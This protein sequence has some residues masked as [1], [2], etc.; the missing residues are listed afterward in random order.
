MTKKAT[1]TTATKTTATKTTATTTATTTR[2]QRIAALAATPVARTN[3]SNSQWL[4]TDK[5]IEQGSSVGGQAG[6]ILRALASLGGTGTSSQI[7]EKIDQMRS[8]DT[9]VESIM[10]G[11]ADQGTQAI[12]SHYMGKQT[13]LI[14]K[15]LVRVG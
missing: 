7:T 2:E 9:A 3:S 10:A 13:T 6:V 14:R 12:V 15:K 4:I 11:K 5:G 8:E 1:K